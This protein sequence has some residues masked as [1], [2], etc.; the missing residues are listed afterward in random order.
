MP[1]IWNQGD[2]YGYWDI[3][4]EET[5]LY[6]VYFKFLD[7]LPTPG[8]LLFRCAPFQHT[9]RNEEPSVTEM[10]LTGCKLDRGE[11]KLE[12]WYSARGTYMLPFFVELSR[13]D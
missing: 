2:I 1:G 6:D 10:K 11:Y 3:T 5:G 9:I 12:S 7:T 8:T 4:V 13:V